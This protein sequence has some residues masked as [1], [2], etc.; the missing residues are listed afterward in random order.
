MVYR[1]YLRILLKQTGLLIGTHSRPEPDGFSQ[2]LCPFLACPK[3]MGATQYLA[4]EAGPGQLGQ[5]GQLG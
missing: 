4:L 5:L 2:G 1:G 3:T